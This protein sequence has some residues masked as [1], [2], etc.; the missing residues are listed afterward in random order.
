MSVQHTANQTNCDTNIN[1]RDI[2]KRGLSIILWRMSVQEWDQ[3]QAGEISAEELR[4]RYANK[5]QTELSD[6][7]GDAE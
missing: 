7:G 2:P 1:G 3:F 5:R 4:K 6:F